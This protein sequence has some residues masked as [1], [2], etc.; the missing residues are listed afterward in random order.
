MGSLE[1]WWLPR[2][3]RGMRRTLCNQSPWTNTASWLVY[4]HIFKVTKPAEVPVDLFKVI[5]PAE[6]PVDL[7]KVIKP[8]EVP[9]D[10][11]KVIK[12]GEVPVD[13]HSSL[14]DKDMLITP[15]H[16]KP[17]DPM[18]CETAIWHH[19]LNLSDHRGLLGTWMYFR[20]TCPIY[21]NI[22]SAIVVG[23]ITQAVYW[24][25]WMSFSD[26]FRC[27]ICISI[28]L[29]A[30]VRQNNAILWFLFEN[31]KHNTKLNTKHNTKR[32]HSNMSL[33]LYENLIYAKKNGRKPDNI[34]FGRPTSLILR[35]GRF[36]QM[37]ELGN[38]KF[39]N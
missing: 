7:F 9:E 25:S 34:R 12:P 1:G 36:G 2:E 20:H 5:K 32:N 6:V 27:Y 4:C 38:V 19:T 16:P 26:L 35:P 22:C 23:A 14:L 24:I 17:S 8:A 3:S 18:K 28:Y 37:N 30:R 13:L 21:L 33:S 10:L 39:P 29:E 11:F 31:T 15:V